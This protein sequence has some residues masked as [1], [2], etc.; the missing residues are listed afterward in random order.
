MVAIRFL[1]KINEGTDGLYQSSYID[2]EGH[3]RSGSGK[4]CKDW[5]VSIDNLCE[6]LDFWQRPNL[7]RQEPEKLSLALMNQLFG[8]RLALKLDISRS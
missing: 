8:Q 2:D 1:A 6:S 3:E 7:K 4:L 5:L